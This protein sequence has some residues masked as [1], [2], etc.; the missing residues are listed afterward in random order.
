[1][2]RCHKFAFGEKTSKFN[3]ALSHLAFQIGMVLLM[4]KARM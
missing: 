2:E 1:M 3:R 4:I